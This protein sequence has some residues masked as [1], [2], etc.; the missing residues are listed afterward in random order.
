MSRW[1]V[2]LIAT[3][4]GALYAGITTDLE[5]RFAE[6]KAVADGDR[7]SKGAKF[8]RAHTPVEIVFSRD[9]CCRA[10]ASRYEYY[11]KQLNKKQKQRLVAQSQPEGLAAVCECCGS[12][13][14]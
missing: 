3:D 13:L 14:S 7:S 1:Q 6:H 2:Y 9:F 5:R 10:S 4:R 12:H 11:L 8:F